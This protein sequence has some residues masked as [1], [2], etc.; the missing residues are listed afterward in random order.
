MQEQQHAK[1]TPLHFAL[2]WACAHGELQQPTT[3]LVLFWC[4]NAGTDCRVFL[5]LTGDACIGPPVELREAGGQQGAAVAAPFQRCNVD[6]FTLQLPVLGPL[7]MAAVWLEG[8]ASLW[9]LDLIVVTGPAGADCSDTS[10][11]D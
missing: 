7:R 5:Q 9:H 8:R 6:S 11:E 3:L 10:L 4:R 2:L 1:C